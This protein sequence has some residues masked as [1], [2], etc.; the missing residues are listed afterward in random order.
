MATDVSEISGPAGKVPE[1]V[2][3]MAFCLS[4]FIAFE[5]VKSVTMASRAA[6]R[7]ISC[8][9]FHIYMLRPNSKIPISKGKKIKRLTS[10][11]ST[12]ATPCCKKYLLF[13]FVFKLF[14]CIHRFN[15]YNAWWSKVRALCRHNCLL[16]P[17]QKEKICRS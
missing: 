7:V 4:K 14:N 15:S 12:A 17:K 2:R 3:N 9:V 13:A 1:L 16:A 5:F 6:C 10:A 8:T 11:N